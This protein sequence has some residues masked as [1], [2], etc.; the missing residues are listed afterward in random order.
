MD[1]LTNVRGSVK[2]SI[3]AWEMLKVT[4]AMPDVRRQLRQLGARYV[5]AD[6]GVWSS[7]MDSIAKESLGSMPHTLE[8]VLEDPVATF[9]YATFLTAFRSRRR[10]AFL[11]EALNFRELSGIS[12]LILRNRAL[13]ITSEYEHTTLDGEI[14]VEYGLPPSAPTP[15]QGS[16]T[17]KSLSGIAGAHGVDSIDTTGTDYTGVGGRCGA[18]KVDAT[19][20]P[21]PVK[22]GRFSLRKGFPPFP[23]SEG[24]A[25]ADRADAT[26]VATPLRS[27]IPSSRGRKSFFPSPSRHPAARFST[28]LLEKASVAIP[29]PGTDSSPASSTHG[30]GSD[31]ASTPSTPAR[32]HSFRRH[33]VPFEATGE[34]QPF[35]TVPL[36]DRR[37][38]RRTGDGGTIR[39]RRSGKRVGGLGKLVRKAARRSSTGG[40]STESGSSSTSTEEVTDAIKLIEES[41]P[42]RTRAAP[43]AKAHPSSG[44]SGSGARGTAT[45]MS[46]AYQ[47]VDAFRAAGLPRRRAKDVWA[48]IHHILGQKKDVP[49][50]LFDEL[51]VMVVL[52]LEDH[53]MGLFMNSPFYEELW[54]I[55]V[56]LAVREGRV[57]PRR[58]TTSA[59]ATSAAEAPATTAKG[60]EATHF[61]AAP[62]ALDSIL[63]S[64][65]ATGSFNWVGRIGRGGYG[66]VHA[67][68]HS[69]SGMVYAIKRMNKRVIK[70]R[71][72]E[73]LVLEERAIM[74][75]ASSRFVTDLK[76]AFQTRE[77]VFLGLELVGGGDLGK[78]LSRSG[79]LPESVAK[80][81]AAEMIAGLHDLHVA[82]IMHRDIKPANVLLTP[83][84]H[85]KIADFGLATFVSNGTLRREMMRA[86]ARAGASTEING[87]TFVQKPRGF[88]QAGSSYLVRPH[89]RGRAGTPGFW[90]PEL[91]LREKV[92]GKAGKY[93]GTADWWS[94]GCTIYALIAGRSPFSVR[95]GDTNDDNRATLSSEPAFP[96]TL[97]SPSLAN[98]LSRLLDKNPETR[99]GA[100]GAREV[101]RH[102]WFSDIVWH[103]VFLGRLGAGSATGSSR[104]LPPPSAVRSTPRAERRGVLP[105]IM[106]GVRGASG[107][108]AASEASAAAPASASA[109]SLSARSR[110]AGP[111]LPTPGFSVRILKG[112]NAKDAKR[113]K[114]AESVMLTAK[115][116]ALYAAFDYE[117]VGLHA[118]GL[119]ANFG[120]V[121][122][123]ES[124]TVAR[125]VREMVEEMQ[126]DEVPAA[127]GVD[128]PR[129]SRA[130]FADAQGFDV[131]S[132]M[133]Q[134]AQASSPSEAGEDTGRV[135]R[136]AKELSYG[137]L[138]FAM[139]DF[140]L[141]S[142]EATRLTRK[143]SSKLLL[144]PGSSTMSSSA[145]PP[146]PGM[147][148]VM[149]ASTTLSGGRT[150]ALAAT[151]GPPRDR[152]PWSSSTWR[153][154]AE[155]GLAI[156][157]L[158]VLAEGDPTA[159]A[160]S[161][162]ISILFD[163]ARECT[164]CLDF[165]R[166][167]SIAVAVMLDASDYSKV[168]TGL[169][170]ICRKFAA[171]YLA[172]LAMKRRAAAKGSGRLPWGGIGS[173]RK[174]ESAAITPS[175]CAVM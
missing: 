131:L 106:G 114:D 85:I 109:S 161:D 152:M 31:V 171:A 110:E 69:A 6:G 11:E 41:P 19:S 155:L 79:H 15:K 125:A 57:K 165:F 51:V 172:S 97:F 159:S 135:V 77:E 126:A 138:I 87:M 81:V 163:A 143:R 66:S 167:A 64:T 14:H 74:E 132:A 26:A 50:E 124:V 86:G 127:D 111:R 72:A 3:E 59:L 157:R 34:K 158:A 46:V 33:G 89:V 30:S 22:P 92:T 12:P 141:E 24:G 128:E 130:A 137:T 76:F 108:G 28:T 13:W 21:R 56:A 98:L 104:D 48:S 90:A 27:A 140:E 91:L 75:H 122:F 175:S 44:S 168:S 65:L 142:K 174:K 23:G 73:R 62:A 40:E 95:H 134:K 84:G 10:L 25:D 164:V 58:D 88:V 4:A 133:L 16:G 2:A 53:A 145:S 32:K 78:L 119:L 36:P 47:L 105:R 139:G 17:G 121:S 29:M 116:D 38:A 71:K 156:A 8:S 68:T 7:S 63:S 144:V 101:M 120:L 5:H 45:G 166:R 115:D 18:A 129:R 146:S 35:A 82:G 80:A 102:P 173:G 100:G 150:L 61:V 37:A 67:V 112:S 42:T 52:G 39:V 94:L 170:S 49:C 70:M 96:E 107:A 60:A 83:D 153:G 20:P 147:E 43:K 169:A 1:G 54:L 99:L 136:S 118:T 151:L 148:S 160:G 117:Q 93:D 154:E 113:L 55:K 162:G 9:E 103:D 149:S 123:R